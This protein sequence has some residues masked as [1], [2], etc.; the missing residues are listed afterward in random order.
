MVKINTLEKIEN[1]IE[2][3]T[4][5]KNYTKFDNNILED[6]NLSI[7][8]KILYVTL[9]SYCWEDG[10]CYP[11]QTRLARQLGVSDRS[12]R[13]W[14][15]GLIEYGLIKK[16]HRLGSSNLY[17]LKDPSEIYSDADY[18]EY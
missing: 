13:T 1:E 3:I 4:P 5:I 14:L 8:E 18:E 6:P 15:N 16:V 2:Y 10:Y 17:F 9:V 11:G 7:Q 12:I